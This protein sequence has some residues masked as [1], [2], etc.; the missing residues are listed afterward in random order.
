MARVYDTSF[1]FNLA[2]D[3][4]IKYEVQPYFN[5]VALEY[6]NR[7]ELMMPCLYCE[8]VIEPK[9]SPNLYKDC[10]ILDE[11]GN[12]GFGTDYKSGA[13]SKRY[14]F[15]GSLPRLTQDQM[16]KLKNLYI[17][18]KGPRV[19][20]TKG[21]RKTTGTDELSGHFPQHVRISLSGAQ[22]K[23]TPNGLLRFLTSTGFYNANKAA[24]YMPYFVRNVIER[25]EKKLDEEGNTVVLLN[26]EN[27]E[28]TMV[29]FEAF[30]PSNGDSFVQVGNISHEETSRIKYID[31]LLRVLDDLS[32]SND[33]HDET[34]FYEIE[35][36]VGTNLM[37]TFYISVL[38]KDAS[39]WELVDTQVK[40]EVEYTYICYSW[41]Y[42]SNDNSIR[43]SNN[44]Q[45]FNQKIKIVQPPLPVPSVSFALEN[46]VK[47][48]FKFSIGLDLSVNSENG[49]FYEM[50]A[51][52]TEDLNLRESLFNIHDTKERF[53]YETQ[54]GVYE[55]YK[56]T[57][58]PY[59]SPNGIYRAVPSISSLEMETSINGTS[60]QYI[61]NI[62]SFKKYYY[63]IRAINAYG[64]PSNPTPIYEVEMTEDADEVFLHT[65][66]VDFLDPKKDKYKNFKTMM[67]LM[68]IIP[69]SE[70]LFFEPERAIN[71]G[72]ILGDPL[73]DAEGR[74]YIGY[75]DDNNAIVYTG[76]L[77][78]DG[79]Y[80][81]Y[82]NVLPEFQSI[83]L[84]LTDRG[85]NL[86][87]LNI[88]SNQQLPTLGVSEN[89]SMWKTFDS[90]GT[91]K[92]KGKKFKVRVTSN[93]SGRKIDLN[94]SFVL[95]KN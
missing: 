39:S 63:I 30:N 6:N 46:D 38:D 8:Y 79:S 67:K 24:Y 56:S 78:S 60:L 14:L 72:D 26:E 4:D 57:T 88:F 15:D 11:E 5:Y 47:N 28:N 35:K 27:I 13:A 74:Q 12:S 80:V 83:S 41:K 29:P 65:K 20:A 89:D 95:K 3:T 84:P 17:L 85:T 70:Q 16:N 73:L 77:D 54:A 94:V 25:Y 51:G 10:M 64:Y 40:P 42:F 82:P 87:S 66:V 2:I 31:Q 75:R 23:P 71:E 50:Y 68:Q 55:I 48:K 45:Q 91:V 59:E 76:Y 52:E 90:S 36:R 92:D 1:P 69:S 9:G 7:L 58:L 93:D 33:V 44:T 22:L 43:R 37:Q 32:E 19:A 18:N 53:V 81:F 49:P 34:I 86:E 61:Q 21:V 62:Q